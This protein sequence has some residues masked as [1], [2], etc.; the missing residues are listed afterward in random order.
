[1]Q[2]RSCTPQVVSN[3][4]CRLCCRS[5]QQSRSG[6]CSTRKSPLRYTSRYTSP[7]HGHAHQTN[8]I[9]IAAAPAAAATAAAGSTLIGC[10]SGLLTDAVAALVAGT[11]LHTY[12]LPPLVLYWD[13]SM[14]QDDV[15]CYHL[16]HWL[17]IYIYR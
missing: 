5:T 14:L 9:C 12:I 11:S 13:S 1:M 10:H 4:L 8:N 15:I 17:M 3:A 6:N 16:P 7:I 2:Y